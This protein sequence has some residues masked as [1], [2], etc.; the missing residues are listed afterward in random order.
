MNDI[1]TKCP[2]CNHEPEWHKVIRVCEFTEVWWGRKSKTVYWA[3]CGPENFKY[4]DPST[5]CAC[6]L[7]FKESKA[8]IV[9]KLAKI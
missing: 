8:A 2:N 9:M 4:D 1:I 7:D 3:Q 5:W 6:P